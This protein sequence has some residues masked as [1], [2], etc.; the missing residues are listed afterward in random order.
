M[1]PKAF[2]AGLV[3]I[4]SN[5]PSTVLERA[6]SPSRGIA[7]AVSYPNLAKMKEKLDSW[8]DEYLLE[9][10]R[11]DRANRKALPEPPPDPE[12]DARVAKGMAELVAHL[13]SGFSPSSV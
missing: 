7:G 3:E 8:R 12:A 6:V 2:A 13:K 9:Q 5:Y 1:D 10:S 4:L 11:L